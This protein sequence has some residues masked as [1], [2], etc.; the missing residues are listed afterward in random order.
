[1]SQHHYMMV[2]WTQQYQ[3]LHDK[4]AGMLV[5]KRAMCLMAMPRLLPSGRNAVYRG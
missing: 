2:L 4:M 3:T 5:Y 1:M